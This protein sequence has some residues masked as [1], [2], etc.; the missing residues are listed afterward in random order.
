[1]KPLFLFGH[2]K[3]E[4]EVPKELITNVLMSIISILEK[5]IHKDDQTM[6]EP[7]PEYNDFKLSSDKYIMIFN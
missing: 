1:M 3:L 2:Q 6:H 4:D 5:S 7:S